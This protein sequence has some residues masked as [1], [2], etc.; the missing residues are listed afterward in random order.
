MPTPIRAVLGDNT[1]ENDLKFANLLKIKCPV[2]GNEMRYVEF[3]E[4]IIK[5]I[6][7][8]G[9]GIDFRDIRQFIPTTE[10]TLICPADGCEIR[11]KCKDGE[12]TALTNINQ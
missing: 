5:D 9:H 8:T 1:M 3:K 10:A 12:L 6:D 4:D 7:M 2:C 11:L